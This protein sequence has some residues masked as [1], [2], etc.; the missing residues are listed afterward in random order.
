MSAFALESE[1]PIK[2]TGDNIGNA[3]INSLLAC[4][5]IESVVRPVS[6]SE[7]SVYVDSAA[8]TRV[9]QILKSLEF[10]VIEN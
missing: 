5:G 2:A 7:T 9:I 6:D 3:G 1:K 4:Q 10:T 8:R